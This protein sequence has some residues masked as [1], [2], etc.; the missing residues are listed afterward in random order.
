MKRIGLLIMVILGVIGVSG[1]LNGK[2]NDDNKDVEIKK[3]SVIEVAKAKL[4]S[5]ITEKQFLDYAEI[6]QKEF[7]NK[8]KGF[9]KRTLTKN[10]KGEYIALVYWETM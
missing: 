4:K 5:D 9:V 7:L 2:D 10:D 6:L 1:C 3:Y 8:Q